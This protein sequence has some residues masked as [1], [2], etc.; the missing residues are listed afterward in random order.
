MDFVYTCPG[1]L[2]D[3]GFASAVGESNDGASGARKMGLSP[4]EIAKVKEEWEEK[5][6]KKLEKE[7]LAKEKEKA[8]KE[9]N[10]DKD[11]N[12]D[13]ESKDK[14]KDKKASTKLPGSLSPTPPVTPTHERYA[15]HRDYFAS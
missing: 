5:Q 3:P 2:K 4:E 10:K 6:K 15:L 11:D 8:E 13:E 12:K 7:K 14:G 1:H 9:K